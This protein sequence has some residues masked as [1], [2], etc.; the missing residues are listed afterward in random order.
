MQRPTS[1]TVIGWVL[2]ILGAFG[3]LGTLTVGEG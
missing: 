3:A 2:L 1:L